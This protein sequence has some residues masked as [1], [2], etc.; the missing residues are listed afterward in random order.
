M[1]SGRSLYQERNDN[2]HHHSV[3]LVAFQVFI[4]F[5][6]RARVDADGLRIPCAGLL[7]DGADQ[8]ATRLTDSFRH[9]HAP[10]GCG[11]ALNCGE[12]NEGS[13]SLLRV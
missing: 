12:T 13:D 1:N 11:P 8:D 5:N 10:L 4:D 6:R 3:P 2:R 9:F 7:D